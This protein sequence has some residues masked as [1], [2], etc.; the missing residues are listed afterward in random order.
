MRKFKYEPEL[1]PRLVKEG[2][3][4]ASRQDAKYFWDVGTFDSYMK[5]EVG[6]L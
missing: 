4:F 2:K 5:A 3:L 1:F 6:Q